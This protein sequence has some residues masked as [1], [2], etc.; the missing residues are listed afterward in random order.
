MVSKILVTGAAGFIGY[1]VCRQLLSSGASVVGIDDM[2]NHYNPVLKVARRDK[3]LSDF[4]RFIFKR[5]DINNERQLDEVFRKHNIVAVIN[6]AARAGVRNSVINPGIYLETN[7]VGVLNILEKM[8]KYGVK[9]LVQASTS[10][11][12]GDGADTFTETDNISKPLSPYAATKIGAEA[13]CHAYNQIHWMDISILR[14]FTVYGPWGRPDLSI[15]RF[16]KWISNNEPVRLAG[17]GSQKRDF[18]FVSDVARAVV[19][20]ANLSGWNV[21]NIGNSN[22]VSVSEVIY[23][24]SS[25][26]GQPAKIKH[27]KIEKADIMRTNADTSEAYR[28]LGWYPSV[29]I[30]SGLR[31]TIDWYDNHSEIVDSAID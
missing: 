3:L 20:S 14:F 9:K 11:V 2:N 28:L 17:D 16:I 13:M 1:E 23:M 22:P 5:Y 27:E 10:S 29:G 18:T 8:R 12:Y 31:Q 4:D 15:L 26:V 30:V 6:L 25:M 24:I 19:G 7:T 21:M